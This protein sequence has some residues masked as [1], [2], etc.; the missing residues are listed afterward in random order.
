MVKPK[1]LNTI[2]TKGNKLETKEK[3]C[4]FLGVANC[5]KVNIWEKRTEE[6]GYLVS[7]VCIDSSWHPRPVTS[8]KNVLFLVQG[9]HLSY[10]KFMF[11]F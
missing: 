4:G 5:R 2:L 10:W 1:S 11:R 8:E 9:G 6:K 3:E 7:F